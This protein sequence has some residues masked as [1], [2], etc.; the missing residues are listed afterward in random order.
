MSSTPSY[1]TSGRLH[2]DFGHE[3]DASFLVPTVNQ[4][5]ELKEVRLWTEMRTKD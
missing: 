5:F 3:S 1:P 4:G 2:G